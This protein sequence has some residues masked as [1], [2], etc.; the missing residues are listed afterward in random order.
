LELWGKE[1][2][3][4]QA[5]EESK[6]AG[7]LTGYSIASSVDWTPEMENRQVL[8]QFGGKEDEKAS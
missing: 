3:M 4:T 1:K 6:K 7:F 2:K 5:K 8:A